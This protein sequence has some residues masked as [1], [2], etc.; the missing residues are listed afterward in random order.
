[1]LSAV[2]TVTMYD[3]YFKNEELSIKD[4]SDYEKCPITSFQQVHSF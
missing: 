1:M 4:V 3:E 2:N